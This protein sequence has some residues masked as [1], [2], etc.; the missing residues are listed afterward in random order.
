MATRT[1]VDAKGQG[2]G[3]AVNTGVLASAI[4]GITAPNNED[5]G[6][7]QRFSGITAMTDYDATR[8]KMR[9]TTETVKGLA[10]NATSLRHVLSYDTTVGGATEGGDWRQCRCARHQQHDQGR[11]RQR[12]DQ[13]ERGAG[14]DGRRARQVHQPPC[15][16]EL[17]LQRRVGT[18]GGAGALGGDV[19]KTSTTAQVR[20]SAVKAGRDVVVRAAN[21]SAQNGILAGAAGGGSAIAGSVGVVVF[22]GDVEAA[23]LR[24]HDACRP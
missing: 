17:W 5:S 8:A 16:V 1:H 4:P 14:R 20:D 11:D 22:D 24:W 21:E 23:I 18:G 9:E 19:F 12:R 2:N 6:A 15:A 13:P 7:L 10:V 3:T